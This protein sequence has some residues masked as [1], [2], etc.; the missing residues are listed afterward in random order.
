MEVPIPSKFLEYQEDSPIPWDEWLEELDTFFLFS[1]MNNNIELSAT[2]MLRYL[3]A[4]IGTEGRRILSTQDFPD[5]QAS[6]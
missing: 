1:E 3:R 6:P 4:Y 5:T 2:L